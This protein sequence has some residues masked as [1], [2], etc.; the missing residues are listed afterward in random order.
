METVIAIVYVTLILAIYM[1]R[2]AL[3]LRG[4]HRIGGENPMVATRMA[5]KGH[6]RF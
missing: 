4:L 3:K 1:V 6:R 5:A 2:R